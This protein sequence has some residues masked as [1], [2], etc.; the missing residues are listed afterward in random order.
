[1]Y[2]WEILIP[3]RSSVQSQFTLFIWKAIQLINKTIRVNRVLCPHNGQPDFPHSV[4]ET[5]VHS[6]IHSLFHSLQGSSVEVTTTNDDGKQYSD[7]KWHDIVAVRHRTFGWVTLDRQYTGEN[8]MYMRGSVDM[9]ML[10]YF[11]F[12]SPLSPFPPH[13]FI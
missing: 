5:Y 11:F 6:F 1:M 12:I 3:K 2:L 7:G 13:N 4:Y 8:V 9:L 10:P